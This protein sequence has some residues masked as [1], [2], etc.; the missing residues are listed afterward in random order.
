MKLL[1][2]I[3]IGLVALFA[4]LAIVGF[5]LPREVQM[6]RTVTVNAT[7]A[8]IFEEVNRF[9]NFNKWSPW[10]QIDPNT[11][12]EYSGPKEGIGAKMAWTS[13]HPD[14]GSGSQEIVESIPNQKVTNKLIF[15][16]FEPSFASIIIDGKEDGTSEVTWTFD[17][18]MGSNPIGRYFGLFMEEMLGP[19]YDEGLEN[20]KKMV[21]SK[22][23][24]QT[25]IE[26]TTVESFPF[27]SI[28]DY[29]AN[30]PVLISTKMAQ[31]FGTLI[32]YAQQ[33]N[34]E[35]TNYP[36]AIWSDYSEEGMTMQC[37][38]PTANELTIDHKDISV[39]NSYAGPVLKVVYKGDYADMMSTYNDIDIYMAANGFTM[40]A[41]PWEEYVTDPT[42][43][44]DTANW[45]TVIYY[46]YAEAGA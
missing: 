9:E 26:R 41:N 14:V 21:E 11:E 34:L 22:P 10:A 1:L 18:D 2:K 43:E 40:S 17:G 5:F 12:Y 3:V 30:D 15:E 35:T 33:N 44:T 31:H 42:T 27:I 20:L 45:I 39:G 13:D 23:K 16:G 8:S 37:A 29:V 4:L 28:S 24:I 36:I 6:Q 7:P 38:L 46:P 25:E 32:Q 19:S